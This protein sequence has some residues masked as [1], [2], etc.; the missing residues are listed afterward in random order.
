[1]PRRSTAAPVRTDWLVVYPAEMVNNFLD[2]ATRLRRGELSYEEY[3]ADEPWPS[4]YVALA[5]P[6]DFERAVAAF[7]S[8]ILEATGADD[9]DVRL[10]GERLTGT[11][12]AATYDRP[13]RVHVLLLHVDFEHH[14]PAEQAH[15]LVHEALHMLHARYRLVIE[16]ELSSI[17]AGPRS[18][19]IA[20]RAL[21]MEEE[22][23]CTLLEPAVAAG[24]RATETWEALLAATTDST[25]HSHPQQD[26][27]QHE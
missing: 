21:A 25:N 16:H 2:V 9:L 14:P 12:L 1:M 22:R 24:L 4:R 13:G 6:T 8:E 26:G 3:W 20:S 17:G 5:D 7:V 18:R 15:T 19:Q 23:I 10:H 27:G 11:M